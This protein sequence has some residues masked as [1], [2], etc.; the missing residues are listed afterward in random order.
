MSELKTAIYEPGI[1]TANTHKFMGNTH[2]MTRTCSHA[3]IIRYSA[4]KRNPS[5]TRPAKNCAA[6]L[7]SNL[8]RR[9]KALVVVKLGPLQD[10]SKIA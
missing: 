6:I 9:H 5:A 8:K 4:R 2:R 3:N 10:A 1:D 7:L